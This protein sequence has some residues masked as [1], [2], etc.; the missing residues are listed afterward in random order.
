MQE[1]SVM[2]IE[3]VNGTS[4]EAFI[5]RFVVPNR[6]VIVTDAMQGWAARGKWTPD[7]LATLLADLEVQ[8]YNDLFDL[9]DVTTLQRYLK[10][11]FNR[12]DGNLSSEYVR[13]YSRLKWVDFVWA[14][15][16]F[17][18]LKADWESPYFL[19]ET[20]YAIPYC[21]APH[22]VGAERSLFPYRGLFV[23]GR[24]AR[25]R[26]HRDPWTTSAVLCQFYGSKQ[27]ILYSPEQASF[28]VR[29]GEHFVD[30]EKPDL[31]RFPDFGRAQ[32]SY[33]D[34]LHPGEILFIPGG[35]LHHVT[36]LTDSISV[37]WNFVHQARLSFLCDHLSRHPDDGELEVLR[38][39][40]GDA[41]RAD[42]STS[43]IAAHLAERVA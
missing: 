12:A 9:V 14:D 35:W 31:Q 29:E 16:A 17:E 36:S 22:T 28:L 8:V 5:E 7:Y 10:K 11:N 6:P 15:E 26:L 30:I 1:Q 38:F 37:T 32:P 19:P 18:R 43:E 2:L 13:W 40:L 4:P 20:G 41:V 25:T 33:R 24:G 21:A 27:I 42:S 23:S 39:F 34:T 3:R